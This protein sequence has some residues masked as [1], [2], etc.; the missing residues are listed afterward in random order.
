MKARKGFYLAALVFG[1]AGCIWFGLTALE[2]SMTDAKA[3]IHL[4]WHQWV[5]FVASLFMYVICREKV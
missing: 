4:Q 2:M 3:A 5:V 1:M